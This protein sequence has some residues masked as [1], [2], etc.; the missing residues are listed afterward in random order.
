[1]IRPNQIEYLLNKIK[2][3]VFLFLLLIPQ[4]TLAYGVIADIHYGKANTKKCTGFPTI[5]PKNGANSFKAALKELKTRGEEVV[6]I[7]G[8]STDKKD[9]KRN[10]EL[11]KIATKS[12]LKVFWL[13]GNHG[14]E[15]SG[16]YY[17][18]TGNDRI[19]VL[20]TNEQAGY[21]GG[22]SETQLEWLKN[23]IKTDKRVLILQH[24]PPFVKNTEE[25]PEQMKRLKEVED[26]PEVDSVICGHWHIQKEIGKYKMFPALTSGGWSII[27]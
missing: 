7:L 23:V 19:I 12:K 26:G 9:S 21:N 10:K 18:D 5:Y 22:V 14:I 3:A 20:D 15:Q 1:M 16:Y 11:K 17:E 6:F 27:Q 13:K 8:D 25:V 2:Y 24:H 4:T